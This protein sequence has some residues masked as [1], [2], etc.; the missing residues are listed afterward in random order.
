MTAADERLIAYAVDWARENP[1]STAIV[2]ASVILTIVWIV[3]LAIRPIALLSVYRVLRIKSEIPIL[4]LIALRGEFIRD[5]F[6]LRRRVLDA[7]VERYIETA[8]SHFERIHKVGARSVYVE[9]PIEVDRNSVG[10]P[11]VKTFEHAF[12]APTTRILITGKGGYGKSTLAFQLARWAM[13]A[14]SNHWRHTMLTVLIAENVTTGAGVGPFEA[15][16]STVAAYLREAIEG[17]LDLTDDF[18]ERLLR[19]GRVLVIVDGYSELDDPTKTLFDPGQHQRFPIARLVYTARPI[20]SLVPSTTVQCLRISGDR[21]SAFVG[22]Y[23]RQRAKREDFPDT[24][25]FSN[26]ERLA[27]MMLGREVTA[28]LA[29]MY[30]DLMIA[31]AVGSQLTLPRTVVECMLDYAHYLCRGRNQLSLT[32]A[33]RAETRLLVD[34]A[35]VAA[36]ECVRPTFSVGSVKRVSLEATLKEMGGAKIIHQLETTAN[37]IESFDRR[38]ETLHF[39]LDPLAEYLAA[40]QLCLDY[41]ENEK[42]WNHFLDEAVARAEPDTLQPFVNALRDCVLAQMET[43]SIPQ[44]IVK[45]LEGL[46]GLQD[47][48]I[49]DALK[50]RRIQ[51]LATTLER[52]DANDEDRAFAAEHLL[53]Y[54]PDAS[55][56]AGPLMRTFKET[57]DISV[58]K[59]IARALE[60]IRPEGPEAT[61]E[62][63]ELISVAVPTDHP[64]GSEVREPVERT[65]AGMASRHSENLE[66]ITAYLEDPR[67]ELRQTVLRVLYWMGP[68]AA[69]AVSKLIEV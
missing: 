10:S 20:D 51:R 7:W 69:P 28:L 50:R 11:S 52:R 42:E 58:R 61:A 6:L 45:R 4:K 21:I 17:S 46:A 60:R 62:L 32:P 5:F 48:E 31:Q 35:C 65:L 34:A 26:C 27:E 66:L 23:L 19:T 18:V 1:K 24:D 15:I 54:G 59:L 30:V 22:A 40:I 41:G 25:L 38:G 44:S 64:E 14:G 9:I 43:A 68:S 49:L 63:T 36:R 37:I 47:D 53:R 16:I 29:T 12:C 2:T 56:A 3:L 39:V 8:R 13:D 67:P 57:E 55:A 33:Q